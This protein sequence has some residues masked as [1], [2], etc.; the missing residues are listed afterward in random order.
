MILIILDQGKKKISKIF[1]NYLI[2]SAYIYE[3]N[4]II[5]T[6]S[7]KERN[8]IYIYESND[9]INTRSRKERN[10]ENFPKLFNHIRIYTKT[11]ILI[12]LDQ[13]KKEIFE[14]ISAYI[15]KQ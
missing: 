10:L 8:L 12:I 7:R 2:I 13:G 14:I 1:Q 3:S 4:D 6:R 11:M 15:R 5:N 9:I